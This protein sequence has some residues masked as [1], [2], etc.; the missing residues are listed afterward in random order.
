MKEVLDAYLA[1][2]FNALTSERYGSRR[3]M[4]VSVNY[5]IMDTPAY[6]GL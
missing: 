3:H 2:Q 4:K 1:G 6:L 5:R